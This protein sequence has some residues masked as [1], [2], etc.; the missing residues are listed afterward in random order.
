MAPEISLEPTAVWNKEEPLQ[1]WLAQHRARLCR[2][3]SSEF[4]AVKVYLIDVDG[5]EE[6]VVII[7][8]PIDL[9]FKRKDRLVI[10]DRVKE[11]LQSER[12]A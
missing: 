10:S 11:V 2:K 6:P 5:S 4:G 1:E 9:S 12:V 8:E 7:S 3:V